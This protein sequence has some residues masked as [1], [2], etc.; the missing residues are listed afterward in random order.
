[1]IIPDKIR[2]GGQDVNIIKE[3]RLDDNKLGTICVAEG[4]LRIADNFNNLKQC[5]SCKFVTFIH[6]VVHG[7]LDTM[8]EFELSGNEKFVC[9]FSSLLIDTIEEIVKTNTNT[10]VSINTPLS[11]KNKQEVQ[12]TED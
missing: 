11:D 10:M 5:E 3:D 4:V 1:M 2:I 8:G 9:T 6:E 12:N 7:I